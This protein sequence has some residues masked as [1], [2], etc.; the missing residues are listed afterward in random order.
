MDKIEKQITSRTEEAG[1]TYRFDNEHDSSLPAQWWFQNPPEGLTLFIVFYT[2]ACRWAQCLGCSLPS[3]VSQYHV[4]YREII[5]QV[6]Y[7]FREIITD[8][9][10]R[11]LRKIIVSNNG[12]IL[13]E[14]TFSTTALFYFIAKM[15]L[16]CPHIGTLT[17]EARPEYADFSELELLARAVAEG[18][19]PTRLELAIGFEAFDEKIR[20]DYFRKGL[21]LE[22]FEKFAADCAR[23]RH[24]LKVYFML[25]PVPQIT[26]EEA[27][28]DVKNAIDYL[29]SLAVS[30]K[31]D[32]NMHLNPTYVPSGTLLE[33]AF[34]EGGYSPPSLENLIACLLHA[35]GRRITI[36]AGID[37]EGLAVPGGTF[38]HGHDRDVYH[39]LEEF[40]RLQD[41]EILRRLLPG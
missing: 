30:L 40:N 23:F 25:K 29:D 13:D 36:Y 39:A 27:V 22:K 16:E 11:D 3:K 8:D 34:Q 24:R 1:K 38:M 4:S 15:N 17:L 41:Y 10:K 26:E 20:N 33:Q 7:L 9:Q 18:D 12:S 31:L 2:Q 32:I 6:D 14:D 21:S 5:K 37:D 35:Q 28:L 19:S